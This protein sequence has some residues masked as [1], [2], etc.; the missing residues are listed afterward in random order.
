LFSN[1]DV[2]KYFTLYKEDLKK[3]GV[4]ME[5]K[6]VEWNT[7]LK[8]IDDRNFDAV[9]LGWG[10]GVVE[11][12]LKQIWHSEAARPGGSNFVSYS[13]PEVDKVIDQAREELDQKKRWALWQ[14]AHILIA[15]DAPYA[16]MFNPKF[17]LYAVNKR[18]GRPKDT[19]K[20]DIGTTY[21]WEEFK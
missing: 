15:E 17:Q 9:A 8:S 18:I 21:W 10:G 1:R 5:I 7:F 13:N 3:A 4:Q 6:L 2:E 19:Y 16:W 14:K 11:S 12:D 20:F